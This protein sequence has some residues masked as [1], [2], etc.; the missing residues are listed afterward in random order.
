MK[1]VL[2]IIVMG[3][4]FTTSHLKSQVVLEAL[5]G[6]IP[7]TPSEKCLE[8]VYDKHYGDGDHNFIYCA[9]MGPDG[10]K[11]LNLNL[12]AEYAREG[13]PHFNPEAI[14]I[15][16]GK[17]PNAFGSLFQR[18]RRAD[19]HEL[20]AYSQGGAYW[21]ADRKYSRTTEK[22]PILTSNHS[23]VSNVLWNIPNAD[24]SINPFTWNVQTD[25]CPIGYR[26]MEENDV[27]GLMETTGHF[28]ASNPLM[29]PGYVYMDFRGGDV[30]VG[31]VLSSGPTRPFETLNEIGLYTDGVVLGSS[32][33][34]SGGLWVNNWSQKGI[35]IL[36]VNQ[37]TSWLPNEDIWKSPFPAALVSRAYVPSTPDTPFMQEN[38]RGLMGI[39]PP[40]RL[41]DFEYQYEN[42]PMSYSMAIRCV[43]K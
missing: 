33:R 39:Y 30:N 19:G 18:G 8:R 16:Y 12:G 4:L 38:G 5:E 40:V 28:F 32:N 27:K 3:G 14:P 2:F 10:K 24:P 41:S 31:L 43:Q 37:N 35:G 11:W 17:D 26:V 7:F 20:V 9:V 21:V 1:K 29:S 36:L 34:G 42:N 15:L 13:S 25:P 23:Y 6:G 22:Q